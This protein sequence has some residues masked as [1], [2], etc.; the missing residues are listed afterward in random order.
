MSPTADQLTETLDHAIAIADRLVDD[1]RWIR[2]EADLPPR[3]NPDRPTRLRPPGDSPDHVPGEGIGVGNDQARAAYERADTLVWD[4]HR[5]ATIAVIDLHVLR[6]RLPRRIRLPKRFTTPDV[7]YSVTRRLRFLLDDGIATIDSTELRKTAHAAAVQLIEAHGALRA[8]LRDDGGTR[9]PPPD[10][11][12]TNCGDPCS[13]GRRRNECEKCA[14]YRQRTGR[15][16]VIRR[17]ADAYQARDRRFERGETHAVDPMPRGDYIDG[18][19]TP[20]TPHPDRE[21]S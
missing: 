5:L 8:V 15:P 12:C 6:G 14:R 7:V 2:A 19:W 10:R 17:N 21:A 18:V 3:S 13:P 1:Y 16:R 4:A 11:R 20:A 9:E